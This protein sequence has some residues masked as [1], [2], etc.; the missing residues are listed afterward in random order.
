MEIIQ[1]I[2]K[3]SEQEKD[4]Q[5]PVPEPDSVQEKS[6]CC[7]DFNSDSSSKNKV[8]DFQNEYYCFKFQTA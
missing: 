4:E 1:I 3:L 2:E 8:V 6:N 7:I 5:V